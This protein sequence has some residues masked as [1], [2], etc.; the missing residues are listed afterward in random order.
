M[1]KK[2]IFIL[3]IILLMAGIIN[4]MSVYSFAEIIKGY[5]VKD[6]NISGVS[7]VTEFGEFMEK[8]EPDIGCD[9]TLALYT[10]NNG[11]YEK[12]NDGIIK[13]G[14]FLLTDENDIVLMDEYIDENAEVNGNLSVVNTPYE[15]SVLGD[16]TKDGIHNQIDLSNMIRHI[17]GLQEYQITENILKKAADLNGDGIINQLD[18]TSSIRSIISGEELTL[19][20]SR[21]EYNMTLSATSGTT[22]YPNA[23]NFTVTNP[24]GGKISVRSKDESIATASVSNST[25]TVTP[26]KAGTV[27]IIVTSAAT[28]NK[29]AS[30]AT[31][32]LTV[33]KAEGSINLGTNLRNFV[34]EGFTTTY[35]VSNHHEGGK[36]SAYSFNDNTARIEVNGDHVIVYGIATGIT[37][38]R[39]TCEATDCYEAKSESFQMYVN[40]PIYYVKDGQVIDDV[41]KNFVVDTQNTII[42]QNYIRFTGSSNKWKFAC[43]DPSQISDSYGKTGGGTVVYKTSATCSPGTYRVHAVLRVTSTKVNNDDLAFDYYCSFGG[44]MIAVGYDINENTEYSC[45]DTLVTIDENNANEPFVRLGARVEPNCSVDI[46][47]LDFY[48]YN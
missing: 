2:I 17:V 45:V 16:L 9:T 38:I 10:T 39:I 27:E 4:M 5:E 36:I 25:I 1:K 19:L 18:I 31:Y 6:Y 3:F 48:L 12:V 43:P 11:L 33:N 32:T 30:S 35:N 22:T 20:S 44:A 21:Q 28:E 42:G 24:N 26:K 15:V 13:T 34:S 14:M 41:F 40:K 8:I 37:T 47:I 46:E 7:P 29:T 23:K